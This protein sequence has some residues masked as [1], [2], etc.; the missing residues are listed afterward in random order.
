MRKIL[1]FII[2]AILCVS[3]SA[4]KPQKKFF[5]EDHILVKF[6][7]TANIAKIHGRT[8]AKSIKIRRD[9]HHVSIPRGKNAQVLV[10]QYKNMPEV[11]Y[12]ELDYY[13]Y[14]EH[15]PNDIN[16]NIQWALSGST[17]DIKADDAWDTTTG[18]ASIIIAILD[19]GI[20]TTH[21][22]ITGKVVASINYTDSTLTD[23]V[24]HGTHVAGIAAANT[25]NAKG[26]AGVG[27]DCK[28]LNVKVINNDGFGTYSWISDGIKYAADYGAHVI[29][30]SLSGKY[31]SYTM[32]QAVN[33]AWNKG[34]V[35]V[36][37]AGNQATSNKRYPA[38]FAN[39][40]SVGAVDSD[41][42]ICSWSNYG[43]Y[44]DVLAPG[45]TILSTIKSGSYS[46]K[47]GTSMACPHVSGL[48]GLLYSMSYGTNESIRDRIQ[49]TSDGYVFSD[50][51]RIDA[52]A[53][54]AGA[55]PT[56]SSIVVTPDGYSMPATNTQQYT[57][58][59]TYSDSSTMDITGS[60][61][62]AS[63]TP[64]VATIT[65]AGLA[66]GISAGDSIISATLGAV[67]D[68]TTLTITAATLSSI[69]V[70]PAGS[71]IEIGSQ[72]QYTATGTYSD[73]S[74]SDITTEV[75]WTSSN[76]GVS[77][78][79]NGLAT[80][81]DSCSTII[82]ATL[83]AKS[84]NTTL[85]VT[86]SALISISVIPSSISIGVTDTKQFVAKG[87]YSDNSKVTIT[88]IVDWLSSSTG[89]ATINSSGVATGVG[90]GS[91][92]ISAKL[93]EVTGYATLTVSAS[94]PTLSSISVTPASYTI[95]IG[96]IRSYTAI[97]NYAQY[98]LLLM[99]L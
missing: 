53:A 77:I 8:K 24:G 45:D 9:I 12:A 43:T 17:Y 61:T 37:A 16:F 58:T 10:N 85:T 18:D 55:V 19:T 21:E 88:D 51:G 33:Y 38:A 76:A 84:G 99:L 71:T 31:Y 11:E 97:A 30:L 2:I 69:A 50:Y 68:N 79:A 63:A 26:I 82:T 72:L 5:A 66:T 32:E 40:M 36:A 23:S 98:G 47:S 70:T 52:D 62:W 90:A 29:N 89:V 96:A 94:A 67:S 73:A 86:E 27:Y 78:D 22:D 44:V 6:R 65:A 46:T 14:P 59:G 49:D 39:C 64:A 81:L 20:L 57:A 54:V 80:S 3:V 60:V 56:L 4:D 25:N 74:T 48:A 15:I 83:G 75:A 42:D 7:K 95:S 28:L 41:G 1:S 93:G 35:I 13:A 87:T 91:T 92:I 34:C